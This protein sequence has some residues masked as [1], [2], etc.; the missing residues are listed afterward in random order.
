MGTFAGL[1]LLADF[2]AGGATKNLTRTRDDDRRI[3]IIPRVWHFMV[4][5]VDN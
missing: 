1:A 3:C 5:V 2:G 4:Q